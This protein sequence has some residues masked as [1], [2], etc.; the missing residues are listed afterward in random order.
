MTSHGICQATCHL[1][2]DGQILLR[3]DHADRQIQVSG[4]VLDVIVA[5]SLNPGPG[6]WAARCS[7]T[8]GGD[9]AALRA[10]KLARGSHDCYTGGVLHV[11]GSN[12]TVVYRI[13]EHLPGSPDRWRAEWP[14]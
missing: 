1:G 11:Y 3:I 14:D 4:E 6:G 13:T 2:D 8:F 10:C 5:A 7:L 12:R 9:W